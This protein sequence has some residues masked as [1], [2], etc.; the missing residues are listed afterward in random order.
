MTAVGF[1]CPATN[2]VISECTLR[3]VH[4]STVSASH[5]RARVADRGAAAGTARHPTQPLQTDIG[6]QQDGASNPSRRNWRA[7]VNAASP[8]PITAISICARHP[9]RPPIHQ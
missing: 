9:W 4:N 6:I 2:A 5:C 7:A 1:Q 3:R 8:A